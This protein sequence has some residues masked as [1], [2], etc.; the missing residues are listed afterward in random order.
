MCYI[1]VCNGILLSHTKKNEILPFAEAQMQLEI[2]ILSPSEEKDKRH[3]TSLI[4]EF[5]N[6]TQMNQS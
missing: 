5:Y 6:M 4:R 3:M 1:N 2:I